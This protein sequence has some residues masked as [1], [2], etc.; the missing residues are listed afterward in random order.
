VSGLPPEDGR[1]LVQHLV[2]HCTH[3]ENVMRHAWRQGD[4]VMW[5]NRCVMHKAD[6]TGVVGRRVLH[7][8]M[9]ADVVVGAGEADIDRTCRS[10]GPQ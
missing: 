10:D 1:A 7:R 4:V 3:D 9:V 5:D 2:E 8:G 6:H